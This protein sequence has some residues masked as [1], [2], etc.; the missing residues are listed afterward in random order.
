[1]KTENILDVA[2]GTKYPPCPGCGIPVQR[3]DPIVEVQITT[4]KMKRSYSYGFDVKTGKRGERKYGKEYPEIKTET[5]HR[6]C[7]FLAHNQIDPFRPGILAETGDVDE[8]KPA[9]RLP[10]NYQWAPVVELPPERKPFWRRMLGRNPMKKK[11]ESVWFDNKIKRSDLHKLKTKFG[12]DDMS[13]YDFKEWYRRNQ[14]TG[15]PIE[16][17]EGNPKRRY[18][19]DKAGENINISYGGSPGPHPVVTESQG[20]GETPHKSVSALG[21]GLIVLTVAAAAFASWWFFI[22][23]KW[24]KGDVLIYAGATSPTYTIQSIG[25][26]G[27]VHGTT[28]H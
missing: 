21:I 18:N 4:G 16:I 1:M 23:T 19:P 27:G 8:L 5:W 15:Y 13:D 22:K 20:S 11:N 24:K 17:I 2:T 7:W 3:D 6:R 14:G 9:P 25:W 12:C 26:T 10:D 28:G